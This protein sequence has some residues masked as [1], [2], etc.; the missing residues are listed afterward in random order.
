MD[1][2]PNQPRIVPPTNPG[3]SRSNRGLPSLLILGPAV[4]E[5]H[6]HLR[7]FLLI[8][9]AYIEGARSLRKALLLIRKNGRLWGE[10]ESLVSTWED[11]RQAAFVT[12]GLISDYFLISGHFAKATDLFIKPGEGMPWIGPTEHVPVAVQLIKEFLNW[13]D[14]RQSSG[15]A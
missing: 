1:P 12:E 13:F 3:D 2:Q 6:E 7:R 11:V 5:K 4:V 10:D 8:V 9:R 15:A 14:M